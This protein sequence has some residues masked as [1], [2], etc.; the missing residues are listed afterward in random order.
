MKT[1]EIFI[2]VSAVDLDAA[3]RRVSDSLRERDSIR[4]ACYRR[5][6]EALCP[7]YLLRGVMDRSFELPGHAVA[8]EPGLRPLKGLCLEPPPSST[9]AGICAP[10]Q[11]SHTLLI[12]RVDA[13]FQP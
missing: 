11:Q 7:G 6:S 13:G 2:W 10:G 8:L 1:S 4:P 12:L 5:R 3:D 9:T